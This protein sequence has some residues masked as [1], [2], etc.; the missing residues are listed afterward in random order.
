MAKYSSNFKLKVVQEYLKG[1]LGFKL[2]AK[3]YRIKSSSMVK[4]WVNQYQTYGKEGLQTKRNQKKYSL[5]FK[6]DVLKFKQDTGASYK[7]TA[8][9]FGIQEPSIIA[10]W[11]RQYLL[12][13]AA[14]LNQSRGRPPK[15]SRSNSNQSNQ[16]MDKKQ[17]TDEQVKQENKSLREENEILRI[18]LEYLKKLRARGLKDPRAN[19]RRK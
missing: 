1:S 6:L 16:E 3:K 11:K 13:G 18:E 8:N 12:K 4:N 9:A 7:E 5:N 15:M 14:G 17:L 19:N 2:L 10:N